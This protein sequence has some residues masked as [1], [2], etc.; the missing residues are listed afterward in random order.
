VEILATDLAEPQSHV[1]HADLD[2]WIQG[3]NLTVT[4]VRDP[5]NQPTQTIQ[6]LYRREYAYVV[7]LQ[8]MKILDVQMGSILGIGPSAVA[9]A[10]QEMMVLLGKK[11]G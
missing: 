11:G 1:S 2:A 3:S 9:A 6:A 5:D 8:T 4:A 10:I 7:D